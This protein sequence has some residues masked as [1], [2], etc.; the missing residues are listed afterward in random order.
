MESVLREKPRSLP[1]LDLFWEDA[2]LTESGEH[3]LRREL[4][5]RLDV[6]TRYERLMAEAQSSGEDE[7]LSNL[8]AQHSREMRVIEALEDALAR[9]DARAA[10]VSNREDRSS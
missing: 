4:A 9:E 1:G 2:D 8:T 7:L 10:Q 6:L 5:H 3:P